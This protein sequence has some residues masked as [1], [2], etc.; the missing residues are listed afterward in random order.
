MKNLGKVILAILVA[1][2]IT[3]ALYN[4]KTTKEDVLA[5]NE[6]TEVEK[7]N[8]KENTVKNVTLNKKATKKVVTT[9]IE[10]VV[11]TKTNNNVNSIGKTIN[12]A[13]NTYL[14][15]LNN[16]L[17]KVP[18]KVINTFKKEGWNIYITGE[19]LAQT[20]FGGKYSSVQGLTSYNKKEIIIE[21][22]PEA[23]RESTIHELGHF[24]DYYFG[25]ISDSDEFT[26]IYN[27][28]VDTFKSNITNSSCVRNKREFFAE[29]FYYMYTD[30]SKTTPEARAFIENL[31]NE[32]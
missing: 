25:F 29:T 28:E 24:L 31:I 1:L 12:G 5:I 17:N 19:N 4:F 27:K 2:A 13:D 16:E 7:I 6:V 3:T 23:V 30:S 32:L 21:N 10:Y 26:N 14:N 15:K 11:D 22:R 20:H 9:K 18:E 8:N